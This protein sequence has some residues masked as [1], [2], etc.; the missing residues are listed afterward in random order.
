M[1]WVL[2]LGSGRVSSR[3]HVSSGGLQYIEI[4]GTN[5]SI[6][7]LFFVYVLRL[8]V[9]PG[10]A[11][12]RMPLAIQI[13]PALVLAFGSLVLPPSPRL[14]VFQGKEDEALRALAQLRLRSGDEE[15][16][17]PILRVCNLSLI[18]VKKIRKFTYTITLDILR[19]TK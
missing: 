7:F 5:I 4:I 2:W 18:S 8:Y 1:S 3:V 10:S 6:H 19:V 11:S 14:L 16:T 12:W 9:V 15:Q 13:L 17:D